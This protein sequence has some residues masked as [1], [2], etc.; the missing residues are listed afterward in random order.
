[1][2][3]VTVTCRPPTPAGF[4][5]GFAVA[6]ASAAWAPTDPPVGFFTS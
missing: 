1:M 6:S 4:S 2:A 5:P 3:A